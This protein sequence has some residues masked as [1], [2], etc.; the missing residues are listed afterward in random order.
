ME[1][2]ATNPIYSF[3]NLLIEIK[4]STSSDAFL[5]ND[6]TKHG[7]LLFLDL[8]ILYRVPCKVSLIYF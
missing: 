7:N 1:T 8:C 2:R 6:S 3:S 4:T 5:L